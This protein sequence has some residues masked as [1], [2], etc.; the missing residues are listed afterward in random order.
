MDP[1]KYEFLKNIKRMKELNKC[2]RMLHYY[3]FTNIS[4]NVFTILFFFFKFISW[5]MLPPTSRK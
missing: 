5:R 2:K 3:V 4:V 1:Y